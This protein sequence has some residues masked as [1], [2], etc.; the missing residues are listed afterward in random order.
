MT[1][2]KPPGP[3]LG[4]GTFGSNVPD[5]MEIHPIPVPDEMAGEVALFCCSSCHLELHG[6]FEPR[7]PVARGAVQ[8]FGGG[9]LGTPVPPVGLAA[10]LCGGAGSGW[11]DLD[12]DVEPR[13]GVAEQ[14]VRRSAVWMGPSRKIMTV[15]GG[16]VGPSGSEATGWHHYDGARETR[17]GAVPGEDGIQHA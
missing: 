12:R 1:T 3:V 16:R 4:S 15:P 17:H 2:K 8:K 6:E 11:L 9:Q 5:E 7:E 13:H 10:C 14:V